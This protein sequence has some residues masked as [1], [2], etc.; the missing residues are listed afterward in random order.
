MRLPVKVGVQAQ[1]LLRGQSSAE[2]PR[3]RVMAAGAC[4][5]C[6]C[7]AVDDILDRRVGAELEECFD[8]RGLAGL[9][10]E[11]EGRHVLAVAGAAEFPS[12]FTSAPSWTR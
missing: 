9:G 6:R 3:Q 7:A 1:P 12:R 11:M 2:C 8:R 10:G 5:A 4:R